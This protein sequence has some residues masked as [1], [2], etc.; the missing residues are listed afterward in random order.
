MKHE[1][2]VV[3]ASETKSRKNQKI[4]GLLVFLDPKYSRE[5]STTN[6]IPKVSIKKKCLMPTPQQHSVWTDCRRF[7]VGGLFFF[8]LL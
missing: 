4:L 8:L 7:L 6:I 1:A 5:E 2:F 3:S